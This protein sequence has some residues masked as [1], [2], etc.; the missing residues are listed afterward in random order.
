MTL[1]AEFYFGPVP[2][3]SFTFPLRSFFLSSFLTFFSLFF[4][5]RHSF[6]PMDRRTQQLQLNHEPSRALIQNFFHSEIEQLA[7]Q[8]HFIS[9]NVLVVSNSSNKSDEKDINN[10]Y[11]V[12][13]Q[14]IMHAYVDTKDILLSYF[15]NRQIIFIFSIVINHNSSDMHISFTRCYSLSGE[16][17]KRNTYSI[18]LNYSLDLHEFY[19]HTYVL[20]KLSILL[21]C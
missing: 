7:I 3:V 1:P 8:F 11:V 9:S 15:E 19:V 5:L 16:R 6:G 20:L 18:I 13:I 21:R 2:F 12:L 14:I 4:F 10:S 17:K